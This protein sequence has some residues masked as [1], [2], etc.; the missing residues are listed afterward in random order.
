MSP[1]RYA[2]TANVRRPTL[3]PPLIPGSHLL[4]ET[5]RSPLTGHPLHPVS[6]CYTVV[7]QTVLPTKFSSGLNIE[8]TV[9]AHGMSEL[10]NKRSTVGHLRSATGMLQNVCAFVGQTIKSA[11]PIA[12]RPMS[13]LQA[14]VVDP[15][16]YNQPFNATASTPQSPST[17][18][19]SPS[20][21][22]SFGGNGGSPMAAPQ[23]YPLPYRVLPP[24]GYHHSP[25]HGHPGY[26]YAQA[27]TLAYPPMSPTPSTPMKLH[28]N[29]PRSQPLA[30]PS[31]PTCPATSS[32][33]SIAQTVGV[34]PSPIQKT[35]TAAAKKRVTRGTKKKIPTPAAAKASTPSPPVRQDAPSSR[36]NDSTRHLPA[37]PTQT[38]PTNTHPSPALAATDTDEIQV[39]HDDTTQRTAP[40][41]NGSQVDPTSTVTGTNTAAFT[42]ERVAQ[43]KKKQTPPGRRTSGAS[44][45]P[46]RPPPPQSHPVARQDATSAQFHYTL[47]QIGARIAEGNNAQATTNALL[48]DLISEISRL[49]LDF[50]THSL[51]LDALLQKSSAETND[52]F[53]RCID[54]AQSEGQNSA[55]DRSMK[56]V[57]LPFPALNSF[58]TIQHV[59]Q[60]P[61]TSF[62]PLPSIGRIM[63]S[64]RVAR[65]Y[66]PRKFNLSSCSLI[67][68]PLFVT[69]SYT[70]S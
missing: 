36:Q 69:T 41:A 67:Q 49:R 11:K 17:H 64:R 46:E 28:T 33:V 21:S 24:H 20:P 14:P 48:R 8:S 23:A 42:A 40:P 45:T 29:V 66:I 50:G 37:T 39:E 19:R 47:H 54:K 51:R 59:F 12:A 70:L 68:L 57:S 60:R 16:L 56:E 58:K 22:P 18:V 31:G 2:I 62:L 4:S 43:S 15:L 34:F 7:H 25:L 30:S 32:P 10:T 44:T 55:F 65:R 53:A 1:Q 5:P 27:Y 6:S 26:M 9:H 3:I 38:A 13:P 52:L 63:Q 61:L 35:K